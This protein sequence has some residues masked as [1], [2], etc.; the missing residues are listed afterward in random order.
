MKFPTQSWFMTPK[1][2]YIKKV[3]T[4]KPSIGY[5]PSSLIGFWPQNE[6]FG[7]ISYDLSGQGND[8]AYIG[9]TLGQP[10]VPG[11]GI[12]SPFYDGTNDFNNIWSAGFATD[13]DGKEGTLITWAKVSGAGVWIDGS[14]RRIIT[15]YDDANNFI[16]LTKWN[17][18]NV[19]DWRYVAGGITENITRAAV[20]TTG[21]MPLSMTWSA[22]AA[23]GAGEYIAYFNSIQHGATL[24]IGGVFA[25]A[26]TLAL[27]SS[28]TGP[29]NQPWNGYLGPTLLY[30]I[31]L[32]PSQI[33]YLSEV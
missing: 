3:L 5:D 8:G 2:G 16:S 15:L 18:N 20:S 29:P 7:A 17:T 1:Q 28:W 10:G 21:W 9:P 19:L 14:H 13:L 24:A 11:M 32:P 30:N 12:T 22:T 4:P 6:H 25:G 33:A 26:I 23:G 31:A 27:L